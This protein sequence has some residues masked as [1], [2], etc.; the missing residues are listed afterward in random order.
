MRV[1]SSWRSSWSLR[2]DMATTQSW[3]TRIRHDSDA[4][5]QEWR[6]ELITKLNACTYLTADETNITPG[7][8]ARTAVNTEQGYAV[9]H[10]N[11]SLH[12]TAPVYF[13]FGFGTG[14]VSTSAPRIQ[15]TVG[16]S[17]NGSGVLGGT[18][19]ATIQS[20]GAYSAGASTDTAR[21]S[22]LSSQPGF[23]GL[24]HKI[25]ASTSGAGGFF[26]SRTC[27]SAGAITVTGGVARWGIALKTACFRF[28]ATANIWSS[29]GVEALQALALLPLAAAASGTTVGTD[30]QVAL[31]TMYTPR[32]QPVFS[33]VGVYSN[34]TTGEVAVGSTLSA[35]PVGSTPRTF[36]VMANCG[37]VGPIIL[38]TAGGLFPAMLWE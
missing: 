16:T 34:G 32:V 5:Y 24:D 33:V 3:S 23:L 19:L 14:A 37:S 25:G 4:T 10:L 2:T 30:I 7:A 12:G 17:T 27:D 22:Y 31:C 9:Y 29:T 13:R 26:F 21:Q 35:T 1:C 28:A 15:I 8:G 11:D 38:T 20:I 18:A 36:L 6:D